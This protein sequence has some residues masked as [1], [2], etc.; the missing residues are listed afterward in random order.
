MDPT[1]VR[2][3]LIEVLAAIQRDSGYSPVEINGS[4]C[5][6]DDLEGFDSKIWPVA[7]AQLAKEA[8]IAIPD[9]KNIF[10]SPDGRRRLTIDQI[11]IGVCALASHAA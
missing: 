1:F 5:P 3:K 6:L 2:A 11:V 7:I 4:T 8:G 9:R 10:V